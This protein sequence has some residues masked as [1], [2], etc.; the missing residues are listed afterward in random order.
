LGSNIPL[1]VGDDTGPSFLSYTVPAPTPGNPPAP[2]P[3]PF[4]PSGEAPGFK[5]MMN[6]DINSISSGGGGGGGG[7]GAGGANPT[8]PPAPPPVV[9]PV[10]PPA[11]PVTL[12]GGNVLGS[13]ATIPVTCA[14]D[15][16]CAGLVQLL[17]QATGAKAKKPTKPVVYGSGRFSVPAHQTGNA[18]VKLTR[19]GKALLKKH[20]SVRM[21]AKTT[22]NGQTITSSVTL[23]RGRTKKK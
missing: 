17:S 3:N 20:S 23:K 16:T 13:N 5:V 8:P 12:G 9:P 7:G 1:P 10:V 19:A 4:G 6:A 2:S 11:N 18:K 15:T 21:V 14:L 22:V